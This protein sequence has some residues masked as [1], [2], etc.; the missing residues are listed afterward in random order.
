MFTRNKVLADRSLPRTG[1]EELAAGSDLSAGRKDGAVVEL[2]GSEEAE[3]APRTVVEQGGNVVAVARSEMSE[4]GPF[5]E[6]LA[7]EAVGVL[8]G[9]AFPGVMGQGEV[10]GEIEGLLDLL[11]AVELDAVVRSKSTEWMGL[12]AEEF[13]DARV[14]LLDSGAEKRTDAEEAALA[15][16]E[17]D[18]AGFAAAVDRIGLPVTEARPAFDA[19]GTVRDQALAGQATTAVFAAIALAPL[20]A[21]AAQVLPEGAAVLFV[22]PD[23]Q[24]DGLMA[25]DGKTFT[26]ESPDDL[27]RTPALAQERLDRDEVHW[28][29]PG[30]PARATAATVGL[31]HRKSRAVAAVVHTAVALDLPTNRRGRPAEGSRNLWNRMPLASHRCDGVSFF[32]A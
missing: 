3:A 4:V 18:D 5:G 24:V 31:L 26:S 20:L 17:G 1:A 14:G 12:G 16:D 19:G 21:G 11:V 6:I 22:R 23:M 27:L 29:I 13:D 30:I 2:V 10:E 25:H 8:A 7:E 28:P 9:A 32:G 15:F